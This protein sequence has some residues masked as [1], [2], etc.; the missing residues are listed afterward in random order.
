[1]AGQPA[2]HQNKQPGRESAMHPEP[3]YMPFYPGSGRLKDKVAIVTGGDSGIGRAVSVLFAREGARVVVVYLD[4][5]EDAEKTHGLIEAEGSEALLIAGDVGDPAFC[6]AVAERTMAAFGRIDILINNAA[7]QH[8]RED[9]ADLDAE[10]MKAVFETNIYGYFHMVQAVLD[11][12]KSGARIINTASIVAYRGHPQLVDYAMTKGAIVA[13]TRSLSARFA[14]K[15]ILVNAVA[16]G[17]IWTPLIPASFPPDKVEEFGSDTP[18]GRPGQPNEV[19]P[20][21]L[22]LA[23]DDGRYMTGQAIHVDGGDFPSS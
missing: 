7:E 15:G 23:C 20:A 13:L 10:A 8:V 12:L 21:Y 14:E 17:P 11:H 1:M 16:P 6:G 9:I 2:Q 19:A 22:L 18:L 3:E 4:E 5:D